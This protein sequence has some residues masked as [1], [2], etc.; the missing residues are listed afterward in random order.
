VG[1]VRRHGWPV[2]VLHISSVAA[3]KLPAFD[4]A[5]A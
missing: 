4:A 2:R 1:Q 5:A 3:H